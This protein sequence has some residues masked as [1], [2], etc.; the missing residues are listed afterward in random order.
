MLSVYMGDDWTDELAFEALVGEAITVR[1]GSADTVSRATY[2]LDDVDA[3]HELLE[4]LAT[5]A[6]SQPAP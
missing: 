5:V 6:G 1:V 4:R 2:R 3:V